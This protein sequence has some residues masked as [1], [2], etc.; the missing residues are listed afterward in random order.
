MMTSTLEF[1]R[2]ATPADEG[3]REAMDL[4]QAAFP[5]KERRSEEDTV[6]ALSDPE[7]HA[8]SVWLE[9]R[10]AALL[11]YWQ[12]GELTYGEFLAV[13]PELRGQNIGARIMEW[14]LRQGDV[15]LEIEPPVDELTCRRRGF[16][17]RLG[18][19][20]NDYH[21]IHPSYGNPL[22]PHQLVLMSHRRTLSRP[23]AEKLAR[24]VRERVMFYSNNPH[25]ETPV[26]G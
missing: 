26:I 20:V 6:R 25:P 21:Y 1:R 13:R 7:F 24:Y 18:F 2:F 16:Y 8:C 4:Y 5:A 12:N 14:F 23:E 11:F 17:E 10:F 9:G 19:V 3:W 15:I 22:D